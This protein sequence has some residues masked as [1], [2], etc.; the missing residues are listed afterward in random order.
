MPVHVPHI[1]SMSVNAIESHHTDVS[2]VRVRVHSDN[3]FEDVFYLNEA[4]TS[5]TSTMTP[6]RA[7]VMI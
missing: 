6:M 1:M 5:T 7:K 3:Y 4:K 2:P